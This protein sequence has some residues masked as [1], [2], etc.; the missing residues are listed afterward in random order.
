MLAAISHFLLTFF[1]ISGKLSNQNSIGKEVEV[2]KTSL[3]PLFGAASRVFRDKS[4]V[5]KPSLD[6]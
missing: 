1:R 3:A 4:D 5:E 6:S 2:T